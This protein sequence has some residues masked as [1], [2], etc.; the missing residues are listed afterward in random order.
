[1]PPWRPLRLAEVKSPTGFRVQTIKAAMLAGTPLPP[2][3]VV[4]IADQYWIT[5][6]AHRYEASRENPLGAPMK[7]LQ[8]IALRT[9][10][11][12]FRM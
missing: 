11:R 12:T 2:V 4:R 5:D 9:E 3:T 10:I 1:V 7:R 6:G 8:A